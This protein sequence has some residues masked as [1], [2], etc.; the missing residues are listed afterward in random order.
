M[1]LVILQKL[2]SVILNRYGAP[3]ML[4]SDNCSNFVSNLMRKVAIETRIVHVNAPL[5]LSQANP[6]ER[7]NKYLAINNLIPKESP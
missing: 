4:F 7:A 5:Y 2:R 3:S 1:K 6:T